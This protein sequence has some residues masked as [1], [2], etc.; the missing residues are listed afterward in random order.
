V[1]S[2]ALIGRI[3]AGKFEILEL[4]GQGAMGRVYKAQHTGLDKTVAL[5][6]L[7]LNAR[8]DPKVGLRLKAEARA[9]SRLDHPN[10]VAV[11]DYGEDGEDKLLYIA[12]ELIKGD[13]LDQVLK[14]TPQLSVRQ[15]IDIVC[16]TLSALSAA[17]EAGVIHRDLKPANIMLTLKRDDRGEYKE[18]VKVCDF[19][20]AKIVDTGDPNDPTAVATSAGTIF[21]TPAYMSP[22]QGRGTPL[23][24]RSDLYSLALIAFRMITGRL[25][26]SGKTAVGMITARLKEA[27][28]KLS[29]YVPGVDPRLEALLLRAMER[30]RNLR[31]QTARE[32][33][34]ALLDIGETLSE[35]HS[36]VIP[37]V[38]PHDT[39]P[40]STHTSNP[41][42]NPS[43]TSSNPAHT[44][45]PMA[46][47]GFTLAPAHRTPPPQAQAFSTMSASTPWPT[48][49]KAPA[50]AKMKIAIGV[51]LLLVALVGMFALRSLR[52]TSAAQARLPSELQ[53]LLGWYKADA[54]NLE[55]D[56]P[57][58]SMFDGGGLELHATQQNPASQPQLKRRRINGLPAVV[59]DGENDYL[60]S[61]ALAGLLRDKSSMTVVFVGRVH[62]DRNQYVFA[63]QPRDLNGNIARGGYA[64]G[65]RLRAK[66]TNTL[67][68]PYADSEPLQVFGFGVVVMTF[69]PDR[70]L[71]R[72]NGKERLSTAIDPPIRYLDSTMFT[73]GQEWDGPGKPSDLFDGE[74]A[75]LAV[76]GRALDPNEARDLELYLGNKYGIP[77]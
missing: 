58:P 3:I 21:G 56:D 48:K 68:P 28:K 75:E 47:R 49:P 74:L 24:A 64:Q 38:S 1:S 6:V 36:R 45:N 16:Q 41:A 31:F 77:L 30:D 25:P 72:F 22:E 17:H 29:E 2:D 40:P 8:V 66:T 70:L 44:S 55:E 76:F 46:S 7:Q 67:G 71:I 19:G 33:R 34:T 60:Q 39:A 9:A 10:S 37:N 65:E 20:I 12:M 43:T 54:L 53:G 59:F 27:P 5:K 18:W 42:A 13:T 69:T 62:T 11:Y 57:V 4:L 15:S 52:S 14:K 35:V 51:G 61:E 73:L 23:D 26:F 63:I 32:M 50:A